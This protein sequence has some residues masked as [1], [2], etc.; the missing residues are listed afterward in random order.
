MTRWHAR[1]VAAV[2]LAIALG[3]GVLEACRRPPIPPRTPGDQEL[4]PPSSGPERQ[5]HLPAEPGGAR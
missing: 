3:S 4:G 2:A 5:P 1:R